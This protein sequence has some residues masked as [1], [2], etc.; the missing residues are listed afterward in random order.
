VSSWLETN[1]S[2]P[3]AGEARRWLDAAGAV[4]ERRRKES[5]LTADVAAFK[6]TLMESLKAEGDSWAKWHVDT[7]R[8]SEVEKF[9]KEL[10]Q[11]GGLD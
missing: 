9:E 4:I 1:V 2:H 7:Y 6:N 3:D 10:R 8:Q 11:K 5:Q